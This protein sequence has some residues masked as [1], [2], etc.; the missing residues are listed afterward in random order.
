MAHTAKPGVYQKPLTGKEAG[1]LKQLEAYLG[2][3]TQQVI[4]H[5]LEHWS[6][7][8]S[9][10]GCGAGGSWPTLPHIGFLLKHHAGVMNMMTPK[11]TGCAATI[12]SAGESS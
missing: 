4:M 6:K 2:T 7:F 10:A 9:K 11:T 12:R 1:Q 3:K 5:A 8:A